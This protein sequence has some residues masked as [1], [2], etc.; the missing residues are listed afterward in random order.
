MAHA[1]GRGKATKYCGNV[2]QKTAGSLRLATRQLLACSADGCAAPATR[3]GHGLCEAHYM[4]QR[5]YGDLDK[6][7][8]TIPGPI[9][10]SH[11][12]VLTEAP[13]H[14]R[15]L[16]AHRAYEHRVVYFDEHGNGPFSCHWCGCRVTWDDMHVDHLDDSKTNNQ[17]GNLVAS[18]PKCNQ[19]RGRWKIVRA[20]RAT[21]GVTINGETLT[22]NEWSA[23]SGIS[24][25]AILSRIK[26]GWALES[27][28]FTR[29]RVPPCV[30]AKS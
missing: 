14:P 28:V 19:R 20:W 9:A 1:S 24:R 2:C 7:P 8:K 30:I 12:Y 16:G 15:S 4:R 10:H 5:R 29:S 23:R 11:G 27:A 21:S 18:C 3:I 22:L 17:I 6:H 13:G 26:K 25:S